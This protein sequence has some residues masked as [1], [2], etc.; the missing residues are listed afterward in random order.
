MFK[1][2]DS[3]NLNADYYENVKLIPGKVYSQKF[4][5]MGTDLK[6]LK[7]QLNECE[8]PFGFVSVSLEND[9][10]QEVYNNRYQ[11]AILGGNVAYITMNLDEALEFGKEYKIVFQYESEL[12]KQ[13]TSLQCYNNNS[14]FGSLHKDNDRI[15]MK[16]DIIFYYNRY[17]NINA[18]IVTIILL[19]LIQ[20]S[21]YFKKK[22]EV[23]F[24]G[25]DIYCG[26]LVAMT[27][28]VCIEW[29]NG[30][31]DNLSWFGAVANGIPI[32]VL[33]LIVLLV[34]NSE[35]IASSITLVLCGLIGICEYYV[36]LFR[37]KPILPWDLVTIETAFTVLDNY[38]YTGHVNILCSILLCILVLSVLFKVSPEKCCGLKKRLSIMVVNVFAI[39]F[40]MTNILPDIYTDI[41]SPLG[42]YSK[43]GTVA[44]FIAFLPDIMYLE[45]LG[46]DENECETYLQNE[47]T[48]KSNSNIQAENIIIIM[49]ETFSDLRMF[50]ENLLKEEYMPNIDFLQDNIIKGNLYVPVYGGGTA[51]SEFEVLTGVSCAYIPSTPYEVFLDNNV[52]SL[53]SFLKSKKFSTIAYHPYLAENWNR[54]EV[55][56]NLGF[57]EFL[58]IDDMSNPEYIRC[59]VSDKSDYDFV[60]QQNA[61]K[62]ENSFFIF[63]VTMQNHGGYE[64]TEISSVDLSSYG[65]FPQAEQYLTLLQESD[66]A[67]SDLIEYYSNVNEPTLICM[68][69]D[70]QASIEEGFYEVLYGKKLKDLTAEE[71]QQM[72]ITPFYIWTNYDIEEENIDKMSANYL[73]TLILNTAGFDLTGYEAFLY[74]LFQ[75]YPVISTTG[76]WDRN[77]VYYKSV[78]EIDDEIL[79][80]YE[81]LQY[82]QMQGN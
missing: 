68:F 54:D 23:H 45:P 64:G 43:Y 74:R 36:V 3:Q 29:M 9:K 76:V 66:K 35:K 47:K 77:G 10:S 78:D 53:S 24:K 62:K 5:C 65:D 16:L 25:Y 28:Y 26:I 4:Y 20:I 44:S 79:T 15:N 55:Y 22:K 70:H 32:F 7:F 80:Q 11:V 42:S 37:A 27:G 59:F 41:W 2:V 18:V 52:S 38:Q 73:S 19:L 61:I 71:H 21:L 46:Y 49:N 48:V 6:Q 56:Y 39:M 34:C 82:Y 40:F 30:N 14:L 1:W 50:D 63:N 33:Y 58:S 69:G 51:N 31:I 57:D 13:T 81:H 8:D 72:Y 67:F 12:E 60:I 75:E 17:L